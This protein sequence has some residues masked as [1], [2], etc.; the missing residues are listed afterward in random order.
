MAVSASVRE[1][2]TPIKRENWG[3]YA[4][5][6]DFQAT[7]QVI[8]E[9]AHRPGL[10]PHSDYFL[11]RGDVEEIFRHCHTVGVYATMVWGYPRG[12]F[13]GGRGFARIFAQAEELGELLATTRS[14]ALP[15]ELVC[16][17]FSSLVDLDVQPIGMGPSTFTKLL[18]FAD[19]TVQDGGCLIY[20]QRVMR[21]I[22]GGALEL[23]D[24]IWTDIRR[25]LGPPVRYVPQ[26][27]Q[28]TSY[29]SF[30]RA[31]EDHG[32]RYGMTADEVE[33]WLFENSPR[34]RPT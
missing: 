2:G 30:L 21:A 34:L 20:D 15:A 31:A 33:L 17:R 4:G 19:V 1:H 22:M 12:R 16:D 25:L 27:R 18:Y 6:A 23:P 26:G 32:R 9:A 14:E 8:L 3:R 13:P 29:G 24:D 28:C 7:F 11:T 10:D 5:S